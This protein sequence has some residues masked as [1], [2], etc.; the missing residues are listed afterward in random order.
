MP[1]LV[2]MFISGLQHTSPSPQMVSPQGVPF[3]QMPP[4]SAPP[5]LGSQ[6][7]FGLS[8]Q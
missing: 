2:Q 1:G 5:F 6:P 3:R 4:Q 7:S 8:P